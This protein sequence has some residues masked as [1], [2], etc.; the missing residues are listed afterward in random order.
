MT[1][2]QSLGLAH[3]DPVSALAEFEQLLVANSGEDPFDVAVKLLAAKL[4]DE[5]RVQ[6]GQATRFKLHKS[7]SETRA[8]I[9]GLYADAVRRWPAIDANGASLTIDTSHLVL[10]LRP[11][12]GWSM[13]AT[14]LSC[15]DATLERLVARDA[16]GQLGQ[17]FTPRE[18]IKLCTDIL[19]PKG[20]DRVIDPACGSGGFL[21]EASRYAQRNGRR[22]PNC[23]GIDYSPKAVRVATLLAAAGDDANIVVSLGNSLDGRRYQSASP[24]VWK[25]FLSKTA[26]SE[27]HR[28][29]AWG[30]WNRL[31]ST[32]IVTNPPFAGEVDDADVLMAYDA[33]SENRKRKSATRECLF[34]ERAVNMLE[35]GGRMAIVLPQGVLANSSAAY[36]RRW[37]LRNSILLGVVGLHPFAFLPYT[38]VKTCVLFIG[39]PRRGEAIPS[40]YDIFFSISRDAGKDSSGRRVSQGDYSTISGAFKQFLATKGYPWAAQTADERPRALVNSEVASLSEVMNADRFDA[41]YFDPEARTLLRK[42]NSHSSTTIGGVASNKVERFAR[43]N[44]GEIEYVDISSVDGKTGLTFADVIAAKDAPSR[45]SY[46]VQPG[47][48]LV[49]TVRPERNV[50]ALIS[51]ASRAP[52]IASNGFCVLRP[53]GIQPELLFAYCKTDTFRTVLSRHATASMYP[54]V[55]ERDILGMPIRRAAEDIEKK[56]AESI[57]RGFAKLQEAHAEIENAI[58]MLNRG[59][60]DQFPDDASIVALNVEEPRARYATGAKRK[61]REKLRR[62]P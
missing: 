37:L 27:N 16:K 52:R 39:K 30:D 8:A 53:H 1:A 33:E 25:G 50:V 36:V 51:P 29:K 38:A 43:R 54:T 56:V 12:L 24:E 10:A 28:A 21:F 17:Y 42:L 35:P 7:P 62:V 41:E 59:T 45:A 57:G 31:G 2:Q 3:T 4:C 49:S 22:S 55:S 18:V 58:S 61:G 6:S 5:K 19:N 14:D 46:L 15:L 23:L 48:V 40:D 26:G 9:D 20:T 34:L 44:F 11:L 32:V 47:D 13:A 60:G